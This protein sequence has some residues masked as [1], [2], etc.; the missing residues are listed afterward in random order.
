MKRR[1][2][3]PTA[4]V[5]G[6]MAM[7]VVG[8]GEP[9]KT[10]TV[11]N[12]VPDETK[13]VAKPAADDTNT[14]KKSDGGFSP[15]VD[16]EGKISLPQ[17]YKQKWAHLGNWAV[18]KKPGETIHEM[19]DV[20]TQPEN[21][22]EFNKTGQFPDGA[23]L[24]KEV[25]ETKADQLTT[26]HSAWSTDMKIWF[27]MI[28]DRKERFKD[29]DHWGDGWG[30]A[31]FEAKDPTKNVSAGYDTSCLGCHVPAKDSDWVYT[32]GYPDLKRPEK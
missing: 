23:V 9:D 4:V 29:S 31:L 12:G 7:A 15:Y 28:K 21:I 1:H 32:Y 17:G 30:W 19:H 24:V 13:T 18:A 22:V 25:R 11:A 27:V 20:Y 16:K 2:L 10:N 8:C 3:V 6:I 14:A 5:L 26:G